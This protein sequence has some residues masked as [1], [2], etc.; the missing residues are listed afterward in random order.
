MSDLGDDL[1]EAM[2]EAAA[3]MEG[4]QGKTSTHMVDVPDVNVGALRKAMRL[5]RVRFASR[6][7][8]DARAVQDWEQGRRRPDRSARVLLR[9]IEKHPEAVEDALKAG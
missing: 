9:V 6:F 7:G 1:I 3:Y 5:S 8:L 2:Q 4:N